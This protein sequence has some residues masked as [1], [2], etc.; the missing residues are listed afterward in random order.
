MV[1]RERETINNFTKTM[2]NPH[3]L[4][5]VLSLNFSLPKYRKGVNCFYV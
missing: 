4:F 3:Y 1:D 5:Q 2:L